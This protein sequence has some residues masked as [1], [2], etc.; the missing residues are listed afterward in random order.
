MNLRNSILI[1]FALAVCEISWG[2]TN[3][4]NPVE[5]AFNGGVIG[6]VT[7]SQI[8]GDGI[9]GFNKL[10]FNFGAVVEMRNSTSKAFQ[11]GVVFNEKGS[12]KTPNTQAG[13]YSTWAYRY[14]YID[15]PLTMIYQYANIEGSIGLQPSL[16]I[17]AEFDNGYGYGPSPWEIYDFDLGWIIG[18]RTQYGEYSHIFT[19]LTQSAI[20]TGPAPD[21]PLTWLDRKT[22]NMTLEFGIIVLVKSL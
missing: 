2:Q 19:R 10:G 5:I 11:I 3:K 9:G 21:N 17:A 20:S 18:L 8:H 22:R 12:R 13:D 4:T 16:L 6:G 14:R 1:C 15:I 7:L